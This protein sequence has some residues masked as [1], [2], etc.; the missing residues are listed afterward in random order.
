MLEDD[1]KLIES[2]VVD[3]EFIEYIGAWARIKKALE[4]QNKSDNTHMNAIEHIKV[5]LE[6]WDVMADH[7][8]KGMVENLPKMLQQ[9]HV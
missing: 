3:H 7:W 2:I 4:S 8:K 6:K 9:H 1:I 5:L